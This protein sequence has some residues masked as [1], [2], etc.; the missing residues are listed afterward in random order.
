MGLFD[1]LVN[2]PSDLI[3]C[4]Q[5][6]SL[7]LTLEDKF[8]A[9]ATYASRLQLNGGSYSEIKHLEGLLEI[10]SR[11]GTKLHFRIM[12]YSP[13]SLGHWLTNKKIA[14]VSED[15]KAIAERCSLIYHALLLDDTQQG[16]SEKMIAA[17]KKMREPLPSYRHAA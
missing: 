1:S 7:Y 2:L 9:A 17:A 5:I 4:R 16:R 12:C 13:K 3:N 6:D 15:A 14:R 8:Q 11:E 10:I